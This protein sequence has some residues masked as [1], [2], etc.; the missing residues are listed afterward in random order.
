MP[1]ASSRAIDRLVEK[2]R[3]WV[4]AVGLVRGQRIHR[5]DARWMA[6]RAGSM[7]PGGLQSVDES[8]LGCRRG[9]VMQTHGNDLWKLLTDRAFRPANACLVHATIG[10][11]WIGMPCASRA[12]P[13]GPPA[14][15]RRARSTE[16]E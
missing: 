14:T 6:I 11:T 7:W 15:D 4:A 12:K 16:G 5:R 8:P 13:T 2:T 9:S 10:V 3:A 1:N